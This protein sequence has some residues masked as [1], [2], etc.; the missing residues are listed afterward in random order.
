MPVTA[1]KSYFGNIGSGTGA[2]ELAVSLLALEK[3]LVPPTLNY[4]RPDPQ[5]PVNVVRD[6]PLASDRP[7]AL[8]LNQAPM[9]QS[10]ALVIGKP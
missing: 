6:Q 9:G 3:Q 5:C 1:P 2:V 7:L 8:A 10:V 4:H